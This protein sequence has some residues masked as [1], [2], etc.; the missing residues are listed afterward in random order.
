MASVEKASYGRSSGAA[1]GSRDPGETLMRDHRP[2]VEANFGQNRNRKKPAL[3]A[4]CTINRFG[5]PECC[6]S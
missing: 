1:V 6:P 4:L 3:P 2:V 5:V